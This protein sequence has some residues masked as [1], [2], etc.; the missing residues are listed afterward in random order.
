MTDPL[1]KFFKGVRLC[2]GTGV[3]CPAHR[4]RAVLLAVVLLA[5]SGGYVDNARS[6]LYWSTGPSIGRAN[7]DGSN[8]DPEFIS[9]FF[10]GPIGE[11]CGIAVN[12]THIFWA[13]AVKGWIGRANIDG[14]EANYYLVDGA[15]EPC[16]V[17]VD[18]SYVYWAN[19][20]RGFPDGSAGPGSIGRARLDG[21][22][23]NQDFITGIDL[24][25][26]VAVNEEFVFWTARL[27]YDYVGRALLAGPTVG[28]PLIEGT[29]AYD[30]CSVAVRDDLLYWGGYGDAIGR[31]MVN[32]EEAAPDFIT[33][34]DPPCA[35]AV[36]ATHVYWSGL[37]GH[38]RVGRAK[39]DRS[40][41][42]PNILPSDS[43]TGSL[44]C[45]VAVD[46][47][48]APPLPPPPE[49]GPE[50]SRC[51][52]KRVRLNY[53]RGT[54]IIALGADY[55]GSVNLKAQGLGSRVLARKLFGAT[56][57]SRLWIK[58]WPRKRGRA[59]K[60]I[61]HQLA[62]RGW[63]K[64]RLRFS[65]LKQGPRAEKALNIK[66]IVL[67]R[68]RIRRNRRAHVRRMDIRLLVWPKIPPHSSM[69]PL[70]LNL[71]G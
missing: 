68:K 58:V 34:I 48:L 6:A 21:T 71:G 70:R 10:R 39:L 65:C 4:T 19:R 25:C 38:T 24:P 43:Y 9:V 59:A 53:R 14:T 55:T 46:S 35:V 15:R 42:E 57:L 52:V 7:L 16:G 30:L 18:D 1:G 36:D 50:L 54:A 33:G 69:E 37:A 32:G 17:A 51:G 49:P 62:R 67:R 8:A 40:T 56:H 12:D 20:N 44:S 2:V 45:G 28:P 5:V 26:G 60:R 63:A 11:A 23:E 27:K 66:P 47:R 31:M 3:V 61:K 29:D 41:V 64:V 13:D 22:G